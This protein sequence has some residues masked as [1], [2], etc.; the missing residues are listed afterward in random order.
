[1]SASSGVKKS[2]HSK[3]NKI[4]PF[5]CK[6]NTPAYGA[7][8]FKIPAACCCPGHVLLDTS[9][10]SEPHHLWFKQ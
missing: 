8:G 6:I 4:K 5:N 2:S 9:A 1:M 7:E 10:S 3:K